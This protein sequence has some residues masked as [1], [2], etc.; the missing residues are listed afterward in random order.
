MTSRRR[1]ARRSGHPQQPRVGILLLPAIVDGQIRYGQRLREEFLA[2]GVTSY[3]G[4]AKALA[5]SSTGT[6]FTAFKGA[7]VS[8]ALIYAIRRY[9]PAVPYEDLFTE[10]EEV[11]NA[12]P[13]DLAA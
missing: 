8:A 2:Q 12:A 10:G 11:H 9:L 3:H 13:A 6:L 7:L 4:M 5:Y 1:K